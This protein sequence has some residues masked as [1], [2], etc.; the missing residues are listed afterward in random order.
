MTPITPRSQARRAA[1]RVLAGV[2]LALA[3]AGCQTDGRGPINRPTEGPP[4]PIGGLVPSEARN[5]VAVLVP[6]TGP[7]A[8]VGQSIANAA[9]LALIDS[10]D[11][12][13]RLTVYNSAG[14]ADAAAEKAL[15]EGNGL[16]LGPLL[17]DEVRAAAPV[18]RRA[19]VPLVAFSNDEG[20]AGNGVYILGF[21]PNQSIDRVV[22]LARQRGSA[23]FAALVPTG[24]YGQRAAQAMLGA[25]RDHG[26]RMTALET[27]NRTPAAVR[28]AVASLNAKGPVDAVL[29]ADG[30][31]IVALAAPTL[32]TGTRLLGTELWAS[33]RALGATP[34]LRGAWY[35]AAPDARFSQLTTR[36]RARYGRAPFRIASLGYDAVLLAVRSSASW[37]SRGRFPASSLHD[38]D[39]F[40]G[41]DGI[42]RFDRRGVA[43][44]ALE[45]RQV[46]AAGTS[47]VS[48]AAKAF[49]D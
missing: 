13:L 29:L 2:T 45:V 23:R 3:L 6:L 15:G 7:D 49:T 1:I 4:L 48:P 19:G 42:F 27:Y 47:L 21:T 28:G 14:G 40:A 26:G 20:V 10:G 16:I 36:Y 11:Q 44:R 30:G 41:V 12:T 34:A 25:V 31:R 39:G 9:N 5:R 18:A 24:L 43:Q 37:P 46:T 38:R 22:G 35:A 17:A 8:A 32:R 33:D